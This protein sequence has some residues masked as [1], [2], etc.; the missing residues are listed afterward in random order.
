MPISDLLIDAAAY[1]EILSFMDGH[2]GYNQIFITKADVHKTA[3]RCPGV[4]GTYEWVVM[5]FSLKN[6]GATYQ[7]AMNTFFHD[8]IGT[9]I[10]VYID[11]VVIKST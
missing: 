7:R 9:I 5:P 8:L 1:H 6:A 10:K 11:D 2:A 3:F 4:L